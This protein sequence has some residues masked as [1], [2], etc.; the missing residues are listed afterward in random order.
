MKQ[1]IQDPFLNSLRRDKIAVTLFL[2]KGVKLSGFIAWFDNFSLLLRRDGESQLVYKHAI[3]TIMPAAAPEGFQVVVPPKPAPG[4][5]LQDHFLHAAI[6]G[7]AGMTL[8]LTNGV[9]LQGALVGADPFVLMLA[10]GDS[11][12]MIFK[13]AVATMRPEGGLEFGQHAPDDAGEAR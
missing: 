12:Q 7:G 5:G 13:H 4:A 1:G 11:L 6:Q 10:R 3:S 8:F 9:M 2:M